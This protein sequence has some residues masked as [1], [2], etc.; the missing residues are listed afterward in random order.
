MSINIKNA[1]T[2][3]REDGG[4]DHR[5]GKSIKN[6][7]DIAGLQTIQRLEEFYE[8]SFE[9]EKKYGGAAFHLC[10]SLFKA[11]L[12]DWELKVLK[13]SLRNLL[14]EL[15]FKPY[16]VTRLIGAAQFQIES[17][18]PGYCLPVEQWNTDFNTKEQIEDDIKLFNY[19]RSLPVR[20]KYELSLCSDD[21]YFENGFDKPIFQ[22]ITNSY[23]KILTTREL[24][25]LRK[26][27][28]KPKPEYW[29]A[30][31]RTSNTKVLSSTNNSITQP[32]TQQPTGSALGPNQ[33]Q[34][35]EIPANDGLFV[36]H[37]DS[38]E[39]EHEEVTPSQEELIQ[40]LNM[41]VNH[42]DTEKV[43]VD[44]AL[45][46]QLQPVQHQ[47]ETLSDLAKPRATRSKYL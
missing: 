45:R 46:S 22:Q 20:S 36:I 44:D 16:N 35:F 23:S 41:I 15:G 13:K 38:T 9:L 12:D 43:F 25:A 6:I 19:I 4:L 24:E 7:I 34:S 26:Q 18:P 2:P 32:E 33:G 37:Q 8:K 21:I 31:R 29:K 39:I 40:Q 17:E 1:F 5:Y 47:L 30:G 3:K 27:Y 11:N 10:L 14:Q 28:P 42:I